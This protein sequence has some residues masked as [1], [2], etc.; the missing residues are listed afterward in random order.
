MNYNQDGNITITNRAPQ[1][2]G[3]VNFQ[4]QNTNSAKTQNLKSL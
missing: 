3:T 4:T 2:A 1:L